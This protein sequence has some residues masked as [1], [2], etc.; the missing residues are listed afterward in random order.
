MPEVTETLNQNKA[1][2]HAWF[3]ALGDSDYAAMRDLMT[4]D[5]ELWTSP[6]VP[7][8][9]A[10]G[11]DEVMGRIERVFSSGRYYEPGTF[12]CRVLDVIAEGDKTV[13]HVIMSGRF[14]NGNPY[15]NVYLV[16][17]RWHEGKMS[18]QLELFDASHWANQHKA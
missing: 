3:R 13:A 18:Y 16:W 15:E 7:G 6:S 8:G 17:M 5:A 2:A 12:G 4:E 11:R 9:S 1:L 14:P 10:I